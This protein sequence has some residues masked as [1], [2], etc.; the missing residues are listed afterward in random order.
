[1]VVLVNGG[2]AS[3][4]EILSGALKDYEKATLIGEKTFGKGV[5]QSVFPLYD[6]S[7]LTV[8][9]ARYYT[10]SGECIHEKGIEPHI[11]VKLNVEKSISKLSYEED[12]QLQKAVEVL[13]SGK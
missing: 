7:G 13:S 9:S 8:T 2:S 4:S 6:G 12:L 11:E 5:V 1:M 10:P 3:A